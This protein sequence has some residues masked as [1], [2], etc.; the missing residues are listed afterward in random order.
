MPM[1]SEQARDQHAPIVGSGSA[2]PFLFKFHRSL[3][4]EQVELFRRN[5]DDAVREDRPFGVGPDVDV[6]QLVDG[7]YVAV[8]AADVV[9]ENY[10][11][12]AAFPNARAIRESE[13]G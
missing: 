9:V 6:Y 13:A 12:G 1:S 2:P 10:A 4:R 8:T 5:W 11:L 7:R 3:S